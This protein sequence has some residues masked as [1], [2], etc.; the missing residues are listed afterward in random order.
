MSVCTRSKMHYYAMTL[1]L[2]NKYSQWCQSK[3][4]LSGGGNFPSEGGGRSL[5]PE[6]PQPEARRA[7]SGG[8]VLGL[9]QLEGLGERCKLLERGPIWCN[10]SPQNSLHLINALVITERLKQ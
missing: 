5:R 4:I 1:Q 3:L 9:H 6:G 8:G 7:S 2:Y 10:L